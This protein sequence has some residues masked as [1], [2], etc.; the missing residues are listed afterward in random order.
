MSVAK[1]H[2]KTLL[3]A[4]FLIGLISLQGCY[5]GGSQLVQGDGMV[6]SETHQLRAFHSIDIRGMFD[7]TLSQGDEGQVILETDSNL[8]ELVS[9]A[10]EDSILYIDSSR[11]VIPRPNTMTLD[12]TYPCLKKLTVGGA[13]KLSSSGRILAGELM[14]D[15][16]GA[17]NAELGME[18]TRLSTRVSGAANIWLEGN[19]QS[20][21]LELSGA[22]NI[23]AEKLLS[24]ETELKLSGTGSAHVHASKRLVATLSGIG[25]IRY[26]GDPPNVITRKTGLGSIRRARQTQP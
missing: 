24:S 23:R 25:S 22:S 16:I 21:F 2:K 14:L 13:S 20:H 7:V 9:I 17:V 15:F 3:P 8:H 5:P 26:Y 6:L 1:H 18:V 19:A 11:E 12:I 10:V 4:V